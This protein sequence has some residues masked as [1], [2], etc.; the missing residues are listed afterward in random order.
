MAMITFPIRFSAR[1]ANASDHTIESLRLRKGFQN[2]QIV[3]LGSAFNVETLGTKMQDVSASAG[4]RVRLNFTFSADS[5]V[6][7][8]PKSK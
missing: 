5:A 3:V 7:P 2:R 4:P 1:G 6:S 8:T